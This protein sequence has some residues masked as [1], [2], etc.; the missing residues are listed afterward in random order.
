[1]ASPRRTQV[2]FLVRFFLLL[3]AFYAVVSLE[4][5]DRWFVAPFTHGIAIVS[6]ALLNLIGQ[7][8][9]VVG[10]AIRNDAFAVQIQNGC[11]G[12]EAVVFLCA[13]ILSFPATWRQRG[14]GILATVV[15][16]EA[17][18]LIRVVSLFLLGRYHPDVFQLFHLAIWQAII[19]GIAALM[20]YGWTTRAVKPAP[21]SS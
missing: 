5:V 14:L 18:N 20:F 9:E 2:L 15:G 19:L 3:A 21:V 6:A 10:T 17:V 7:H 11:N 1:M 12:L 8:V 16:I 13:A 4:V